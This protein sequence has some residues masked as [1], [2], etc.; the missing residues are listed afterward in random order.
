[1]V[2]AKD[3][4]L[5]TSAQANDLAGA[6]L[7]EVA[8]LRRFDGF[9]FQWYDTTTGEVIRNPRDIDCTTETTPTFDNCYFLSN[10]DNG[11]YASGLIEVR[12]ALPALQPVA[13]A[14]LAE[15]N[16]GTL[17]RQ[18]SSDPLERE[19]RSPATSRPGR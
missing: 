2:A 11:C 5:I 10:V 9:L 17:L 18:P 15:M 13:D 7:T 16:F 3:L 19:R 14:L 12:Q 6:T 8:Q 1:M 4:G